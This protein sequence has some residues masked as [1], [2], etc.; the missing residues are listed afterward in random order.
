MGPDVLCFQGGKRVEKS[1][2]LAKARLLPATPG[3]YIMRDKFDRVIYVGKSKALKNRVSSYFAPGGVPAGKTAKMVAA[4]DRFEVY[5]TSTELEALV[6]ENSFIKQYMPHYN[7][8]LKDSE[9]YPYIKLTQGEYPTLSVTSRHDGDRAK[10]YGPFSS[11]TTAHSIVGSV[12]KALGLPSCH[13]KFPQDIGKGRPCLNF[14]IG[15]CIGV[16]RAGAVSAAELRERYEQAA[17][18]LR[19]D[20]GS[21]LR[22]LEEKM[23]QASEN[24]E[25]E[26]AAKYRDCIQNVRKLGDKQHIVASPDTECDVVGVYSDELGGSVTVL[27]VRGGAITDRETFYFG[28]DEILDG[29]GLVSFIT[30]FYQL[31]E[32]IPD[33][34]LLSFPLEPEETELL[35]ERLYGARGRTKVSVPVRGEKKELCVRAY[36]NAKEL[37]LHK[38]ASD[39]RSSGQLAALAELLHL[40]VLPE[41]IEAYDISNSGDE[42]I[43]CG[44]ITLLDGKFAKREYKLFN[45]KKSDMQDDYAAMREAME[46]RIAH[47][48][49]WGAPDLILLDGGR[50]H[51]GVVRALLEEKGVALPVFG[52]VKDEHHKTRTLTD[53]EH[54]IG[55]TKRQDIFVFVYKIQEEVHRFAFSGMDAKRRKSVRKS[56][57][58][59]I[60]GVGPESARRLNAA[61]GGL[62]GVRGA[63]AEQ[64]AA[65]K[66]VSRRAAEAVYRHFHPEGTQETQE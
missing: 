2:L 50:T 19:G 54:D 55:L 11:Y 46:R 29:S 47:L 10:Y 65:V 23:V 36:E 15:Q 49:D 44:M 61:F 1:E 9:G 39:A 57:L 45:I 3:V 34:I 20:Y 8:K 22:L 14:H 27:F 18:L 64:L 13:K 16:C 26:R 60:Q 42:H 66:G 52:M 30:R 7:I 37:I 38:R 4:V 59:S 28:A 56:T 33:S 63:T 58:E 17:H 6:L 21:L 32:Y 35:S 40:E 62:R 53:G 24:L 5:H 25:F 43:T 12:R 41:R 31:R 51:V 48:S